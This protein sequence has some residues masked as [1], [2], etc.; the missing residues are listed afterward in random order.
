MLRDC[1]LRGANLMYSGDYWDEVFA[2]ADPWR[3]EHSAYEAWKF[4]LTLSALGRLRPERALEIGCAEG[5]L[6]TRLAPLV[7]SLMASD[8]SGKAIAR[9][10]ARAKVHGNVSFKRFDFIADPLPEAQVDLILCSEVLYYL[11]KDK[12]APVVEKFAKGLSKG[13]LLLHC[14]ANL[15][16]DD[17][18]R[19]GF[20]WG[21]PFGSKT[22]CA[23]FAAIKALQLVREI[24][25]P[26]FTVQ[27]YRNVVGRVK[28]T[29][30][31]RA[32]IDMPQEMKLDVELQKTIVWNGAAITREGARAIEKANSAPILMYHAI[33]DEGPAEL[34]PYRLSPKNFREQLRWLRSNG[35]Y[36]ISLSQFAE[37][38]RA[39]EPLPGR[40]IVITFDD[41]FQDFFENAWLEL[42]RADFSATVFIVT[43]LAGQ[44]ANWD[45]LAGTAPKLMDWQQVQTIEA[46]GVEIGSHSASHKQ[47]P[48]LSPSE[49]L[50]EAER[51]RATLKERLGLDGRCFA[52]PWGAFDTTTRAALAHA[53]YQIAVTTESALATFECDLLAL[54]RI[55]VLGNDSLETFVSKVVGAQS[56][57]PSPARALRKD[58]SMKPAS[59]GRADGLGLDMPIRPDFARALAARLDNLV[60][61]FVRM[62][63]Q[64][65]N[66]LKA[67]ASLQGKL[68]G[69]F[70]L[71]VTGRVARPLASGQEIGPNAEFFFN[72]A[73]EATLIIDVKDDHVKSPPDFLNTLTFEFAGSSGWAWMQVALEWGEL[74]S[75]SRYQASLYGETSRATNVSLEL[76]LPQADGSTDGI[77]LANFVWH[78]EERNQLASGE[79]RVP[80]FISVDL[81]SKP[82]LQFLFEIDTDISLTLQYLN[83][84]FA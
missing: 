6:T 65:L 64:L 19:T 3:Y 13:G 35:Y 8:I 62:Q 47:M 69:L 46:A 53:G 63:N 77:V 12:L 45:K 2:E 41:G 23:A 52:Y 20:D 72:A 73:E 61:E 56:S 70:A 44:R 32:E 60:G 4:G 67:P 14:H 59:E 31:K 55:E 42:E 80:D 25:T 18:G 22:I 21:H 5:H 37:H 1:C 33:D 39:R 74:S 66:E 78:P 34:A 50:D 24:R 75:A 17:P 49:A 7:G 81:K 28:A 36:S 30:P 79:L 57:P 27:L 84:H 16:T 29:R 54:P 76:K 43:D 11:P 51:S 48:S 82:K 38:A 9:A 40:P 83:V 10:K 71:P 58:L 15:V 26:L 68:A